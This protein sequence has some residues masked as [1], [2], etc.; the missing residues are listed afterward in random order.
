MFID[1]KC[2]SRPHSGMG[3][4]CRANGIVFCLPVAGLEMHVCLLEKSC[5]GHDTRPHTALAESLDLDV[6]GWLAVRVEDLSERHQQS[7]RAEKIVLAAESAHTK[8]SEAPRGSTVVRD[9]TTPT[10]AATMRRSSGFTKRDVCS[11]AERRVSVG[12]WVSLFSRSAS[13]SRRRSGRDLPARVR[14]AIQ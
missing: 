10:I 4:L 8:G 2:H 6:I 14:Q 7:E 9:H 11:K 12:I 13:I 3:K 1:Q 5:V